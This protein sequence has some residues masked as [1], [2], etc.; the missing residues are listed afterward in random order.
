MKCRRKSDQPRA[1]IN[2]TK[3]I[4]MLAKIKECQIFRSCSRSSSRS[5]LFKLSSCK[6]LLAVTSIIFTKKKKIIEPF[7]RDRNVGCLNDTLITPSYHIWSIFQS[8]STSVSIEYISLI[9][10]CPLGNVLVSGHL[11]TTLYNTMHFVL[12]C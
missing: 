4:S 3:Y 12:K 2:I 10:R 7:I 11:E 6:K 9:P 1:I 5:R 8:T